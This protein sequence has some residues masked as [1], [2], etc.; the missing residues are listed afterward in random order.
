M[1]LTVFP[2]R[3]PLF[4]AR[5]ARILR[6][7]TLSRN[8]F[9]PPPTTRLPS[10]TARNLPAQ[11]PSSIAERASFPATLTSFPASRSSF[12][13][14]RSSFAARR[15]SFPATSPSSVCTACNEATRPATKDARPATKQQSIT[16][17]QQ[18][19]QKP[20][21][22]PQPSNFPAFLTTPT[23]SPTQQPSCYA[24]PRNSAS[25]ARTISACGDSICSKISSAAST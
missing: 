5:G 11:P 7:P 23:P 4:G 9:L 3:R 25:V 18:R 16:T 21:P 15:A 19:L 8:P 17:T 13:A 24:S 22:H 12:P 2:A 10:C 20:C 6:F 1:R 14:I